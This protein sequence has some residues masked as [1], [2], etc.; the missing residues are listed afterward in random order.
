MVLAVAGGSWFSF[1]FKLPVIAADLL[2]TWLLARI[3]LRRGNV[4]RRGMRRYDGEEGLMNVFMSGEIV[5]IHMSIPQFYE[6][7]GPRRRGCTSPPIPTH[8]S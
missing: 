6:V 8:V 3:W 7:L 1:V 4:T 5:S 2:S